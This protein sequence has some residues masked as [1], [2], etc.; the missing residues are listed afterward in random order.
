MEPTGSRGEVST[1]DAPPPP[2]SFPS[3]Q[4]IAIEKPI[5]RT[6]IVATEC[7]QAFMDFL[8][9]SRECFDNI[10]RDEMQLYVEQGVDLDKYKY[11]FKGI[12]WVV[13][14]EIIT[15]EFRDNQSVRDEPIFLVNC[16]HLKDSN[17]SLYNNLITFPTTVIEIFDS[18]VNDLVDDLYGAQEYLDI[19]VIPFN[20]EETK[21]RDLDPY[22][23]E[24]LIQISGIII[25]CERNHPEMT[26]AFYR[27][28][29]CYA[30]RLI[31]ADDIPKTKPENCTN[32][33]KKFSCSIIANRSQFISKSFLVLQESLHGFTSQMRLACRGSLINQ[34]RP[35]SKVSMVGI[36]KLYQVRLSKRQRIYSPIFQ[37]ECDVKFFGDFNADLRLNCSDPMEEEFKAL[38]KKDN[39]Y[40]TFACTVF[41][42]ILGYSNVKKGILL[43]LF[44][45]T[46]GEIDPE[47]KNHRSDI[48]IL[49]CG[50]P[51]TCKS[52]FLLAVKNFVPRCQYVAGR[53]ATGVG[54]TAYM[55]KDPDSGEPLLMPGALMY[56]QDGVCCIDEFDKM[57]KKTRSAL[58]EIME[59]QTLSVA[60]AGMVTS[61]TSKASLLAACNPVASTWNPR[62]SVRNNINLPDT[63][64]SRFDLIF[65]LLDEDTPQADTELA[66]HLIT[67]Y[68]DSGPPRTPLDSDL[69][70]KYILYAKTNFQP[71]LTEE[72]GNYLIEVYLKLLAEKKPGQ[73][74]TYHRNL[75]SLIRISEAHARMRL[76]KTVEEQDINEAIRLHKAAILDEF[77]DPVMGV[78]DKNMFKRKE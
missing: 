67:M 70:K 28:E 19:Q 78:L 57:S 58:H 51:S 76:S 47:S 43:L 38:S 8:R 41:P 18:V 77:T 9:S 14:L 10:H 53:G 30:S 75:E 69:L 22:D 16:A 21:I 25:R 13:K 40:E 5:R 20:L 66:E 56:C 32:C 26:H 4:H 63:L 27:C 45:G 15:S 36:Y 17:L 64:L 74:T 50:E 61:L 49:L 12:S 33:N 68:F 2:I 54:L 34:V 65:L 55:T 59:H 6:T 60:K 37:K 31:A 39:A 62:E 73:V 46:E 35:G 52:Q 42:G 44:G 72:C 3:D 48:N 71:K 11:S 1:N 24:T 7:K 23:L 29:F